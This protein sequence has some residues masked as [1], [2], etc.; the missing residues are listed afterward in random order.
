[1]ADL[2]GYI[3]WL[4]TFLG[5]CALAFLVIGLG[6][7]LRKK[8]AQREL[9]ALRKKYQETDVT[10]PEYNPVRALYMSAV[11]D[12]DRRSGAEGLTSSGDTGSDSSGD[13]GGGGGGD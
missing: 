9:D 7:L 10:D 1:M 6:A 2:E 13:S 8:W 3:G 4:P 11:I 12:H 5:V